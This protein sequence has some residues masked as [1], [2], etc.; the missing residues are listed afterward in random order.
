MP[1]LAPLRVVSS[2]PDVGDLYT[3]YS[4]YVAGLAFRLLGRTHEVDDLVQDVFLA[5]VTGVSALIDPLAVRAWLATLTVRLAG[6]KLRRRKVASF[7]AFDDGS[8]HD[9]IAHGASAEQK[10]LLGQLYEVLADLNVAE[11][12]AWTLHRVE[13]ETLPVVATLCNCSLATVKHRIAA[14]E[15]HLEEALGHE[16]E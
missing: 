10:T 5:A 6:R 1:A 16:P 7:F 12:V 9:V 15:R 8:G 2:A 3:Q 11:R 13:G 4:S 14:A